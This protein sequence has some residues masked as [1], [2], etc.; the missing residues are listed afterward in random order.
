M[1]GEIKLNWQSLKT[2][3]ST[4]ANDKVITML[5]F[6]KFL[7]CTDLSS[8]YYSPMPIDL[9]FQF[10][11][12]FMYFMFMLTILVRCPFHGCLDIQC[13]KKKIRGLSSWFFTIEKNLLNNSFITWLS[14]VVLFNVTLTVSCFLLINFPKYIVQV[15]ARYIS[16]LIYRYLSCITYFKWIKISTTYP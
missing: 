7:Y 9:R 16:H 12:Y 5:C 11:M 1:I 15:I 13:K 2:I 4:Y 14:L 3:S 10:S 6:C 8:L